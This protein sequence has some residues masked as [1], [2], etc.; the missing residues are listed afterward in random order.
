GQIHALG[1]SVLVAVLTYD[2]AVVVPSAHMP[3]QS[4]G[5]HLQTLGQGFLLR[6]VITAQTGQHR[7]LRPGQPQT[8]GFTV[9]TPA[10][11]PCH[12]VQHKSEAVT[13]FITHGSAPDF[14]Y[15]LIISLLTIYAAR[16]SS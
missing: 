3:G 5:C 12:V 8:L 15:D 2:A 6:A 11:Q 7:P 14:V 16:I 1:A 10:H 4:N 13:D 9:K